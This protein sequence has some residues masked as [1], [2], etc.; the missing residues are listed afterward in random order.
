MKKIRIAQIG[1]GH[2]HAG[3]CFNTLKKRS[4]LFEIVGVAEPEK[5][6]LVRLERETYKGF[7]VYTVDEILNM[8]DLDAVTVETD[9][10]YLSKYAI[11]AAEKKLHV[12]MDK[13]G[14]LLYDDFARLVEIVKKNDTV[15]HLGYMY[16]YNPYVLQLLKEVRNGEFGEIF[17]VEAQMNG[18]VDYDI[19]K[20]LSTLPGGM[21]FFLGCHLVDLLLLIRGIPEKV[22]PFNRC[23]GHDGLDCTDYGMA[24]FTYKNGVSFLKSNASELGGFTRRQLVVTGTKKSV[25]LKPFETVLD[26]GGQVTDKVEYL[27][28]EW[29]E[30]GVS[31]RTEPFDR[32]DAMLEAFAK[33]AAGEKKNPFTPDYELQVFRTV[34]QCCNVEI[35]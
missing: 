28:E 3:A 9:E 30:K 26:K 32:Y 18:H 6:R 16:R 1:T 29:F 19:R 12:H 25:E 8:K 10:E 5:E 13:P 14:G 21:M 2:T 22:V 11:A 27:T 33:M 20:W 23:T 4:D 17:A 7:P 35:D 24:V 31:S 15:L 34:L